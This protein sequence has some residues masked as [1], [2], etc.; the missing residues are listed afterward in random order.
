MGINSCEK[1]QQRGSSPLNSTWPPS[2]PWWGWKDTG[3]PSNPLIIASWP[4]RAGPLDKPCAPWE[5]WMI[6]RN[7]LF[8][9]LLRHCPTS[10]LNEDIEPPPPPIPVRAHSAGMCKAMNCLPVSAL[11]CMCAQRPEAANAA[12]EPGVNTLPP[13]AAHTYSVLLTICCHVLCVVLCA[14][15]LLQSR[16]GRLSWALEERSI[17]KTLIRWYDLFPVAGKSRVMAAALS[18]YG[19]EACRLDKI[20]TSLID[21]ESWR[22][23]RGQVIKVCWGGGGGAA[24]RSVHVY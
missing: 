19:D 8:C 20:I 15:A 21:N 11:S 1:Q 24:C 23:M 14:P 2:C 4:V 9:H 16:R 10:Q 13:L 5:F 22:L 18:P 6:K 3:P 12:V 7:S 17:K